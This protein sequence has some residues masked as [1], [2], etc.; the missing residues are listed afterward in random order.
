[1]EAVPNQ[2]LLTDNQIRE[3]FPS[4][5]LA[6]VRGLVDQM[7]SASTK[8]GALRNV[9]SDALTESN[10][11]SAST[12]TPF[13]PRP[14]SIDLILDANAV[15]SDIRFLVKNRMDPEA[16]TD[17]QETIDA[18][19]IRAFAPKF[20]EDEIAENIPQI[21]ERDGVSEERY[22][23]EW[24]SYKRRIIFKDVCDGAIQVAS[25]SIDVA[26]EEDLPYIVLQ[27]KTG[28]LIKSEDS[29]I[30]EMGGKTLD[31]EAVR[32]LRDYSRR[33][34]MEYVVMYG[35]TAVTIGVFLMA[36]KL[37]EAIVGLIQQLRRL[38]PVFQF[39]LAVFALGILVHPTSRSAI[40]GRV[41]PML[42][43][44]GQ[45]SKQTAIEGLFPLLLQTHSASEE[46]E[47]E[48]QE[49]L[50]KIGEESIE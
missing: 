7:R 3:V 35:G 26:D 1:M 25:Q 40:R 30:E 39:V 34:S 24:K 16:R 38:P 46:A 9:D 41:F 13:R 5:N 28:A 42:R 10:G 48:L 43:E 47:R 22:W 20:L 50:E 36:K 12:E 29:H 23:E 32:C 37:T 45:L 21:A 2:K 15:L 49:A 11:E 18:G 4:D 17:L 44:A 19:T 8:G 6:V 33:A 14:Y 27:V 31:P